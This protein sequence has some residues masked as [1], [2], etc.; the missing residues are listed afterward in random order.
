M[1]DLLALATRVVKTMTERDLSLATAESLSGGLLGA[2]F[3][4]VPGASKVYLGGGIA[5]ATS[6]KEDMLGVDR[7]DIDAFTVISEQVASGM[8]G[9]IAALTR[10]DWSVAVTGAAGPDPQ[11]GH[12]PG[13]VWICVQGPQ[14]GT[15]PPPVQTLQFQFAGDRRAVREATVEAALSMLLRIMS[16]VG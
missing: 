10:A 13:E 15:L 14:I 8:A 16:P 7:V 12:A 1:T 11:E 4:E 6:V 3:T 5:Y 2:T 9:G